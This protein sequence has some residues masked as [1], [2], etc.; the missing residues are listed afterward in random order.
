MPVPHSISLCL[1]LNYSHLPKALQA[2]TACNLGSHY[3]IRIGNLFARL[4]TLSKLPKIADTVYVGYLYHREHSK[5][6]PTSYG[7]TVLPL[8]VHDTRHCSPDS[9]PGI[10]GLPLH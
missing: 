9:L 8:G 3:R 5:F 4:Y 2:E 6:R 1:A 7:Y 10:I